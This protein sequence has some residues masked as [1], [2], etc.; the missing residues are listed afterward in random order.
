MTAA[1]VSNGAH[2]RV[3]ILVRPMD[4]SLHLDLIVLRASMRLQDVRD[5][6]GG[7]G[8]Q[9]RDLGN[10]YVWLFLGA[11]SFGGRPAGLSLCFH[12]EAL[13]MVTFGV[14]LPD[15][16]MLDGWPSEESSLRQVRF[17][18]K[19]LECQLG[20]P[21]EEGIARFAWGCAWSRFDPKGF[22]ASAGVSY[23]C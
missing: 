19:E 18:K 16:Q 11:L 8:G 6:L 5:A 23:Q 2:P 7:R 17:M 22:M 15:D 9:T 12:E 4:G 14:S 13:E 3:P 20:V 21:L 1:E 10:G